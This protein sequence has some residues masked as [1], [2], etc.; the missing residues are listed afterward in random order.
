MVISSLHLFVLSIWL[1]SNFFSLF[2]L[3]RM[4]LELMVSFILFIFI[5]EINIQLLQGYQKTYNYYNG[6]ARGCFVFVFFFPPKIVNFCLL[7]VGIT[8]SVFEHEFCG[9]I[10]TSICSLCISLLQFHFTS[11]I[12]PL[13]TCT[14]HLLV[15]GS[16]NYHQLLLIK[17]NYH[18]LLFFCQCCSAPV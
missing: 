13:P 5:F 15:Q 11:E 16:I 14:S 2:S 3:C 12:Y 4:Y 1:Q 17:K 6:L 9:I 7:V 8:V 18:Q 10:L